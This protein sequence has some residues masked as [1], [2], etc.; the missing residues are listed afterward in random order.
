M[1]RQDRRFGLLVVSVLTLLALVLHGYHP[2]A[3]D[4]GLYVYG[5]KHLLD[6]ALYPH[7]T[8]FVLEPMG[9]SLF[10]PLVAAVT[11]VSRL[12][13]EWVLLSLYLAT[14]WSTLLAA[15]MLASRCFLARTARAGAVVLMTCW[16][17]LPVAGT[18]LFLMDPYLTARSFSTPCTLLALAGVLDF[19]DP[20]N[21]QRRRRRGFYMLLGGLL[22]A[23]AMHPL[24]ASYALWAA[25]ILLCIRSS[26]RA[27]ASWGTF[28][29]ASVALV[30][31]A[32]LQ[33]I[34]P[35]ESVDYVRVALTRTY[36]FP[37][38][39]AWYELAG[40]A[41][42]LAILATFARKS[43]LT[44][45]NSD[46]TRGSH[47]QYALAR[48]SLVLGVTAW[49]AAMFFARSASTTH[50]LARLQ[51]LRVF[52]IIYLVMLTFLG[53]KL[54]EFIL[55]RSPWRWVAAIVL[56]G[57]VMLIA[58]R[59]AFPHSNPVE[60]PWIQPQNRWV[61]AFVWIRENT[62]EDAL[63]ALDADYINA[64]GEDAQSFRAIAERSSLPDYSKDGGEASIAPTLTTL[65]TIGQS[66]QAGLSAPTE[67]D[68][69]R[70]AALTPLGVSWVVLQ[71]N[72][73]THLDCPYSN[74]EV[75]V[76]RLP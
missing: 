15:W 71:S 29:L 10:A 74:P 36:W 44:P 12:D 2:Y 35:T 23:G 14:I 32:Y 31:A 41:A 19:T 57:G 4:G 47:A 26:N 9:Y 65:W 66:A 20:A 55:R 13:L 24:M 54:G 11:R 1:Q 5:V 61:Q 64:P 6:P 68:A 30:A 22:F 46:G 21:D 28:G 72:A 50:L 8:A 3:E 63:F 42:P 52:Q 76:C 39:W 67:T 18:A 48:M 25:F 51:P 59:A 60:A 45:V 70:L 40:L 69:Q 38:D 37:A 27:V 16:L 33:R 7:G 49:L 62:P 53:A 75:R 73:I 17:T 58:G 56:L 43:S 34:A